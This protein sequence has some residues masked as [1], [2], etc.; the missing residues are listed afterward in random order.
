VVVDRLD[1]CAAMMKLEIYQKAAF[2][3]IC[4]SF[5]LKYLEKGNN[6]S[7]PN[8]QEAREKLIKRGAEKQLV[9]FLSGAG[10][11]GKSHV[12]GAAKSMCQHFCRCISKGFDSSAFLV[13]TTTN[14]AAA[15]LGGDTIHSVVQLRSRFSNVSVNGIDIKITWITANMIIIG[16]ISML[17]LPDFMKLD[18][19]LRKLMREVGGNEALPFGG[20]HIILC[21]VFFSIE[22]SNVNPD[23]QQKRQCVVE[24]NIASD[25]FEGR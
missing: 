2:N 6:S 18:K 3:I 10:G 4:S 7:H 5:M 13:T 9:M 8:Y 24:L 21:G 11:C 14:S 15:M 12:I 23:L 22:P 19:H 25:F 20:L 17:S 16:E 1:A